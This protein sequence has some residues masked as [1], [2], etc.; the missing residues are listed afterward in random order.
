MA[1]LGRIETFPP[2]TPKK[3]RKN[4]SF[5]NIISIFAL[6]EQENVRQ[7]LEVGTQFILRVRMLHTLQKIE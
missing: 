6:E 4:F 1:T 2:P 3:S 5:S 7:P